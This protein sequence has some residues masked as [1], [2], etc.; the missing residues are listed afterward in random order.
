[1]TSI[2]P[3]TIFYAD[4][5]LDPARTERL[6]ADALNGCDDGELYLQY[7]VISRKLTEYVYI[8]YELNE[9]VFV[10]CLQTGCID[11]FWCT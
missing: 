8:P 6:V 3:A 9:L 5:G 11:A 2:D 10:C 4:T 1:M 7:A